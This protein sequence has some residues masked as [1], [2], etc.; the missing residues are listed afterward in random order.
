MNGF[1]FFDDVLVGM[2][3]RPLPLSPMESNAKPRSHARAKRFYR[4]FMVGSVLGAAAIGSLHQKG[5]GFEGFR[6][7]M[8]QP[9]AK[10]STTVESARVRKPATVLGPS[11]LDYRLRKNRPSL[12]R[13]TIAR[14]L[15]G[16]P[17]ESHAQF[18][19]ECAKKFNVDPAMALAHFKVESDFGRLG[20]GAKR[21]NPANVFGANKFKGEVLDVR[22]LNRTEAKSAVRRWGRPLSDWERGIELFFWQIAEGSH[23]YEQGR[24]SPESIV[25][26]FAPPMDKTGRVVND[27][28][29]YVQSVIDL[30]KRYRA[31][32]RGSSL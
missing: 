15:R 32:E 23:Y 11:G 2:A 6:A 29:A 25:P 9:V 17:L 18:I 30:V 3:R 7:W 4:G 16:S 19:L 27:T 10:R 24:V 14:I 22:Y 8:N 12:S 1:L 20:K 13:S 26:V 31:M 5:W 28:P 21:F